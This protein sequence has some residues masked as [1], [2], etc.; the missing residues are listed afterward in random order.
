ML[1]GDCGP[2]LT[3]GAGFLG[4]TPLRWRSSGVDFVYEQ[5]TGDRYKT[6]T[7]EA[8]TIS[9]SVQFHP[10]LR[11]YLPR[12][13]DKGPRTVSAPVNTTIGEIVR[14]FWGL[15]SDIQVF[16]VVNGRSRTLSTVLNDGDTVSVFLAVAGG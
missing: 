12:P 4:A 15:P 9:V 6:V 10:L 8:D 14:L 13:D 3:G 16:A 5:I 7:A 11:A 2:S 1:R